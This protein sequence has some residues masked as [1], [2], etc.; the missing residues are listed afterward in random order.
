MLALLNSGFAASVEG[1][2]GPTIVDVNTMI[3]SISKIDDYK[4]VSNIMTVA[5][6][7]N[8]SSSGLLPP[9]S[10]TASSCNFL[11]LKLAF[12]RRWCISSSSELYHLEPRIQFKI[13]L[14]FTSAKSFSWNPFSELVLHVVSCCFVSLSPKK[15]SCSGCPV[16]NFEEWPTKTFFKKKVSFYVPQH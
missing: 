6:C 4:M 7:N 15:P 12:I 11:L 16:C 2:D 10:T 14:I 1:M 9:P 5:V 8:F 13:A 3:R